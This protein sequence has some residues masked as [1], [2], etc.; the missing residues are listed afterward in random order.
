M[1]KIVAD[2]E[3]Q[4][5]KA[6]IRSLEV[7]VIDAQ[8]QAEVHLTEGF[9]RVAAQWEKMEAKKVA[10]AMAFHSSEELIAIKLEFTMDSYLEGFAD[11]RAKVQGLF[12]NINLNPLDAKEEEGIGT[13]EG[14]GSG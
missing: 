11:C 7:E 14:D 12:P 8:S 10:M 13:K 2:E 4:S 6:K 1:S 3:V 9:H 5:L